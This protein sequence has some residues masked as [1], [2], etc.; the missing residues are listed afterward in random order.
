MM[1]PQAMADG[2]RAGPPDRRLRRC[3]R[4]TS[5]ADFEETYNQGQSRAGRYM[6]LWIRRGERVALRLGVVASRAVGN[7]V[8]RARAKRRLR[9]AWRINRHHLT[10]ACDVVLVAR[11]RILTAQWPEIVDEL[12]WLTRKA[13]LH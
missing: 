3:Q 4:V 7:A 6:V 2:G 8:Q 9:E 12:A 11:R 1:M 13:G 10:G 5:S